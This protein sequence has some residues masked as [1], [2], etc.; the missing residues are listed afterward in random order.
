MIF[1]VPPRDEL[2]EVHLLLVLGAFPIAVVDPALFLIE[3]QTL[4]G[5]KRPDH[6]FPY[7]LGLSFCPGPDPTVD[8][9]PRIPPG[10][11]ALRPFGAEEF[12]ANK[13]GQDLAGKEFSQP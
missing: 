13:I 4:Q 2:Q 8:I 5:K 6:V 12:L 10:E 9:E 11:K 3:R 1:I 7:P